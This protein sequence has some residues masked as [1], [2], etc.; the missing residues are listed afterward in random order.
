M[1][2]FYT[3]GITLIE[4][5]VVLAVIALLVL[6]ILP[7]FSRMRE[8]QVVKNATEETLSALAKARSHTLSSLDSS[9]YGVHF[10]SDKIIIFKGTT[11]GGPNPIV[12]EINI[13]SPASISVA[14]SGGSDDIFFNRLSGSPSVSG[15][16]TISSSNFT[17]V[18]DISAAGV[19]SSN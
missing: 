6:I 19:I 11:Y 5:I 13:P 9:E 3:K 17:K 2:N 16:V 1:K 8:N 12:E 7:Q 4:L 15:S 14:L 18:V 10:E